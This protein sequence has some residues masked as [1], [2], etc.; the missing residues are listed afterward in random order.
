MQ[1]E[2]TNSTNHGLHSM[3]NRQT[4]LP[5]ARVK[6]D[7]FTQSAGGM[8]I[9]GNETQPTDA[10]FVEYARIHGPIQTTAKTVP[11]TAYTNT[12]APRPATTDFGQIARV[13]PSI[14]D[15]SPRSSSDVSNS[16]TASQYHPGQP[17]GLPDSQA[18]S[19][20]YDHGDRHVNDSGYMSAG[21]QQMPWLAQEQPTERTEERSPRPTAESGERV[22]KKGRELRKVRSKRK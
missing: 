8:S 13:R 14:D 3:F 11:P 9:M 5:D 2:M 1:F 4:G 18:H 10:T 21:Q 6:F 16:G 12:P 7:N 15:E 17:M 20:Y 19:T 22:Q